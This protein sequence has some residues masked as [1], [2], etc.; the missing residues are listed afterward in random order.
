MTDE[1]DPYESTTQWLKELAGR[2]PVR[3]CAA[4]TVI[5]PLARRPRRERTM[6]GVAREIYMFAVM[7]AAY[8]NYYFMQVMVE[9]DSLPSVVVFVAH[10]GQIG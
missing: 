4:A 2:P 5:E 7:A 8:G 9:M 3:Q 6:L 10:S 1:Q